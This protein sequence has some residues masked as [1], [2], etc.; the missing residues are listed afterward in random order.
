MK[1]PLLDLKAQYATIR[2]EIRNAVDGVIDSQYFILGPEV[3]ALEAEIAAYTGARYAVGVASGSDAILVAMMQLG[4]G[5]GDAVVTTPY[6]FFATAGS[7]TRTGASVLF[8]DIDPATFNMDPGRFEDLI[9]RLPK[10]DGTPVDPHGGKVRGVMPVHLFGQ[11]A[12]MGSIMETARRHNLFVVEDAAQAIGSRC[13]GGNA[14]AIG[15]MG[16]F[17]FFPSKNLGGFGDGGM[18]TTSSEKTAEDLKVLR[19]HGSKPKY[20]HKRVGVNSRLDAL[21]AAVLRVKLRHLDAWSE[22]RKANAD[23][24]RALFAARG[25]SAPGGPVVLPAE[26]AGYRHIYNQFVIMADRRDA[27]REHLAAAGIGTEI[28]YPLPLHLQECYGSLGYR[29]GDFANSEAAARRSL[30]LPIYPEL[31][32]EMQTY[33]VDRIAAFLGGAA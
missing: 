14:G 32:E 31:T 23:R 22:R 27:L 1:V 26:T 24:Y 20:Y 28:Y 6:S 11:M 9:K 29:P 3:E 5:P 21:Q 10:K 12:D 30:A 17:S 4:V 33:V 16:C 7:I 25:F 2:D 13:P 8:V 15:E 18:I 19:N